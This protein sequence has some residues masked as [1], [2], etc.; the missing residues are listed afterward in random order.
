LLKGRGVA[1]TGL[2]LSYALLVGILLSSTSTVDRW[3]Q[4][5]R[6][7]SAVANLRT[8]AGAE[9]AYLSRGRGYGSLTA[10]VEAGLLEPRFEGVVSCYELRVVASGDA[11][12]ATAVPI[13]TDAGRFGYYAEADGVI[14][15][16]TAISLAPSG[17]SG[18]PVE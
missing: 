14:R 4:A 6:E 8:I 3:P 12:T 17:Y 10:L 13:S 16:S 2:I 11:Y 1:L 18:R 9:A 5:A 15:Y 7:S